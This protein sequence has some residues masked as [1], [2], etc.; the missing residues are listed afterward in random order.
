MSHLMRET[1]DIPLIRRLHDQYRFLPCYNPDFC[2]IRALHPWLDGRS[3]AYRSQP[4]PCCGFSQ[5]WLSRC[6]LP[7]GVSVAMKFST[8]WPCSWGMRSVGN[9]P[10]K[11]STNDFRPGRMPSWRSSGVSGCPL[12]RRSRAFWPR[13]LAL[14]CPGPADALSLGSAGSPAGQRG[15]CGWGMGSTRNPVDRLRR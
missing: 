8:L 2:S 1:D 5:P 11:P 9:A 13:S 12:A 3:R 10:L 7:G 14:A 4:S 15:A 6:A